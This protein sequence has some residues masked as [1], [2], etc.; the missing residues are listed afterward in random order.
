MDDVVLIAHH[1]LDFHSL[2]LAAG[3]LYHVFT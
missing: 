2:E 3:V 1:H